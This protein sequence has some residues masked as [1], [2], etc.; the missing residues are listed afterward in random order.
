[1]WHVEGAVTHLQEVSQIRVPDKKTERGGG[2][3]GAA[4][5]VAD[6]AVFGGAEAVVRRG[7]QRGGGHKGDGL[8]KSLHRHNGLKTN[9]IQDENA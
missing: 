1:M 9:G 7:D 2:C 5:G 8:V 3:A 4:P 6:G